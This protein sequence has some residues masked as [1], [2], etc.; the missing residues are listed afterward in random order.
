M[1]VLAG[2]AWTAREMV[3]LFV[4]VFTPPVFARLSEIRAFSSSL[5]LAFGLLVSL[6]LRFLS[7]N[8]RWDQ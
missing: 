7:G 4:T 6:P 2:A 1:A 5:Y 3:G 8:V